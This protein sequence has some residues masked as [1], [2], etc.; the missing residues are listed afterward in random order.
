M[1]LKIA[2]QTVHTGSEVNLCL[3]FVGIRLFLD[4]IFCPLEHCLKLVNF[5]H[6][7]S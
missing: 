7:S 1:K 4:V 5:R 3:N 6:L 2:R